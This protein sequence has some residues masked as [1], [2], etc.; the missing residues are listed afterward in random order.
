MSPFALIV[1][2]QASTLP[3][4]F[5]DEF[6]RLKGMS[7]DMEEYQ[8]L[9]RYNFDEQRTAFFEAQRSD[10]LFVMLLQLRASSQG[11]AFAKF[12]VAADVENEYQFPSESIHVLIIEFVYP[13]TPHYVV[14]FEQDAYH[15]YETVQTFSTPATKLTEFCTSLQNS[16]SIVSYDEFDIQPMLM[17]RGIN[18]II[19]SK[20]SN[21]TYALMDEILRERGWRECQYGWGKCQSTPYFNWKPMLQLEHIVV[22]NTYHPQSMSDDAEETDFRSELLHNARGLVG[23]ITTFVGKRIGITLLSLRVHAT[24]GIVDHTG[25]RADVTLVIDPDDCTPLVK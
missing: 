17:F 14:H 20:T 2:G 18:A 25:Q 16:T 8:T 5:I 6:H 7:C 22:V 11:T 21:N 19:S 9:R 1:Y 23:K 10:P 15:C 13:S 12:R 4:P 3:Q 24:T